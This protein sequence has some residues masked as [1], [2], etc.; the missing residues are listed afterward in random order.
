MAQWIEAQ[1]D[2]KLD[3]PGPNILS[4]FHII[5]Y[6]MEKTSVRREVVHPKQIKLGFPSGKVV[7][8]T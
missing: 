6:N 4:S 1:D 2:S 5:T 3:F 8:M 7:D